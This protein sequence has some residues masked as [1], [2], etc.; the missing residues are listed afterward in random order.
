MSEPIGLLL[1]LVL[2]GQQT[3]TVSEDPNYPLGQ[4]GVPPFAEAA[5]PVRLVDV[6]AAFM[7]EGAST[8]A[9][10]A[11]LKLGGR[12]FVGGELRGDR[13]GAFFDTQRFEIGLTEEDG[14]IDVEGSLRAP[15]FLV[16]IDTARRE[17]LWAFESEGSVRVSSDWELLFAYARDDNDTGGGPPSLED[18][19]ETSRLPPS[20]APTRPLRSSALGF[21]YQRE[22]NLEIETGARVSRARTEAGFELDVQEFSSRAVWNH[23]PFE[24]DGAVSLAR[25]G[26]TRRTEGH[27][28]VGVTLQLGAHWVVTGRTVQ[29]WQPD[30]ELSVRD[31]GA[32]LTLFGRRFRFD[33]ANETAAE[34]LALQRRVNALGYNERRVYRIDELRAL[35]DRLSISPA[36]RELAG[37]LNALYLA[38][39]RE[40]NVP[41]LG[42]E[43]THTTREVEG[44]TSRGYRAFVGVPWPLRWP[45]TT[46]ESV[47][48]FVRVDF[49]L[50]E[51][52]FPSVGWTRR[53]YHVS[54]SVELNRQH[55]VRFHWIDPGQTPEELSRR[56]DRPHQFTLEYA[57]AL[58]R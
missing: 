46:G 48:E 55:A 38:Q 50:E 45:F 30:V 16:R 32:G 53:G 39:V 8:S 15:W 29:A 52:R 49:L 9:F 1:A 17:S 6:D 37:A 34:M 3:R 51:E 43:L 19:I 2:S 33:R 28:E 41:Q 10:E 36:Q 12:A 58:G 4:L 56:I 54:A 31:Y 14:R 22:N 24:L 7:E 26:R 18:F 5:S 20:A 23:L 27:A 42:I 40:R 21:L 13:L 57:Y 25:T 44:S 35:R 11:R 47:V